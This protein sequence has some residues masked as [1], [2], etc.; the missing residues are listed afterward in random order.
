MRCRTSLWSGSKLFGRVKNGFNAV[1]RWSLCCSLLFPTGDSFCFCRLLA[2]FLSLLL[3]FVRL[4]LVQIH[5][6]VFKVV[7]Y[8]IRDGASGFEAI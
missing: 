8:S 6:G 3:L 1:R 4:D 5:I 2:L 7:T